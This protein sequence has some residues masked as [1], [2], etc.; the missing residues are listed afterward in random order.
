[1]N[2]LKD[3][4]TSMKKNNL[5]FLCL[6]TLSLLLAVCQSTDKKLTENANGN[7]TENQ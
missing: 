3:S 5:L 2:G 1:M 4:E 7:L 6:L